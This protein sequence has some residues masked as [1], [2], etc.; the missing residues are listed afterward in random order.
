MTRQRMTLNLRRTLTFVFACCAAQ[1]RL[2]PPAFPL[3]HD[4]ME[5]WKLALEN[6]IFCRCANL[7]LKRY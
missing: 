4:L 7:K 5:K 3:V 1:R 6:L 2:I